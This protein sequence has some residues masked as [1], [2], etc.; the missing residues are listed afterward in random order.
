MPKT[1]WRERRS[2]ELFVSMGHM[3]V[4]QEARRKT[5]PDAVAKMRSEINIELSKAV[6]HHC[7]LLKFLLNKDF[8]TQREGN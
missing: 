6:A 4:R 5:Q 3:C 1:P 8:C 2:R 7:A